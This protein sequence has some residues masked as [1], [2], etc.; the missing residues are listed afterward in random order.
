MPSILYPPINV[1]IAERSG[2]LTVPWRNFFQ[3]VNGTVT[4]I[5]GAITTLT[6]DV[7]GGPGPGSVAT[8][9]STT[10][11]TPGT[12]GDATHVGQFTV[13][14]K[15]RLTA[16]ANVAITTTE[17]PV[18]WAFKTNLTDAQF[19]ALPTTYQTLVAAP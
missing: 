2:P 12:Y 13:D 19:K 4:P 15:G 10:G 1:D 7:T 14:T 9:L 11:V 18:H 5:S 16:A 3:A 6:G 8:T 17:V